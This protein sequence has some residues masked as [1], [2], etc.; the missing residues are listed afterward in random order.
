M[1][2]VQS[3]KSEKIGRV[4]AYS[5]R[6][7]SDALLDAQRHLFHLRVQAN[8]DQEGQP[9]AAVVRS[10]QQLI[11]RMR[12]TDAATDETAIAP[13]EGDPGSDMALIVG[14]MDTI[15]ACRQGGLCD[16]D[17]VDNFFA[18]TARALAVGFRCHILDERKRRPGYATGLL[19]IAGMVDDAGMADPSSHDPRGDG[20]RRC[21]TA[22]AADG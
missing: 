19:E 9:L 2:Y 21:G 20:V 6:F 15:R 14:F 3:I 18:E 22:D 7:D 17:T 16:E 4:L 1:Q 11:Q 5:E 13:G 8:A 10:E 12:G